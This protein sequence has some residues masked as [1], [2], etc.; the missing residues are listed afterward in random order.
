M[1]FSVGGVHFLAE[2]E[3]QC[4][5]GFEYDYQINATILSAIVIS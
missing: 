1:K 2:V 5:R 4:F 3:S